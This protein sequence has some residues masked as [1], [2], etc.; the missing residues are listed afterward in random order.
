MQIKNK[1]LLIFIGL[2]IGLTNGMLGSGGGIISVLCLTHIMLYENRKAHATTILIILPL[3][4]ISSIIFIKNGYYDI[5]LI[6]RISISSVIGGIIGAKILSR[7]SNKLIRIIFGSI[8]IVSALRM[9][10]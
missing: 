2:I 10:F 9:M 5:N 7:L 6:I 8:M 4:I 3:C 1:F